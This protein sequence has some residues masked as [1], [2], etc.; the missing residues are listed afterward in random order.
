MT[1]IFL[2]IVNMSISASWIVLAV[3]VLRLLLKKAPKWI[4]VLLWGIVAVRLIC[5]F[6]VE[7]VMSLIPSA[8]TISPE[9]MLDKTPTINSGVAIINNIVNPVIGETFAPDPVAS[10]NPLQILIPVLAIAWIVGIVVMLAYTVISYLRVKRKIGTAVWLRDNI[11]QSENVASPFVLGIIKPAIY[12]PFHMDEQNMELVTAHEQAHIRRRDHWWKPLGFLILTLHWFNP[13]MWL[14]YVLLC[15]DI[16]LAC[17]EKVIKE[18]NCEQKADY[19][20][21]LLTCSVNRRVIAACPVAFGEVGVKRRIQSVMHYKKP[22]FWIVISALA[23]CIVLPLVFLTNPKA[24]GICDIEHHDNILNR[25]TGIRL[26]E[27][28]TEY[29]IQAQ[30]DIDAIVALLKKVEIHQNPNSSDRSDNRDRTNEIVLNRNT[31]LCF[32]ENCEFV[33]IDDGVKPSLSYRVKNPDTVREIFSTY[34]RSYGIT[35]TTISTEC[36]GVVYDFLS[37]TIV[38]DFPHISVRWTNH[39][40][41]VLCY[42]EDFTLYK[43]ETAVEPEDNTGFHALLHTI[44]PGESGEE[45]YT[46]SAYPLESGHYRLEKQF[47]LKSNPGTKYRAFIRFTVNTT[48]AFLGKRYK[49]E[50]IV[51]E[52]GLFSYARSDSE[53][54]QFLI[55]DEDFSLMT[56]DYPQATASSKMYR[57]DGLQKIEL[58]GSNFDDLLEAAVWDDG[59]SAKK[60]R[61]N[62]LHAF[63]SFDLSGRMYYLLEQKN[64]D[65]FIAE[66]RTAQNTFLWIYKMQKASENADDSADNKTDSSSDTTVGYNPY[67]HAV[68]LEVYENSVLVKPFEGSDEGKSA[69]KITV[70]TKVIST[71]PVPELKKGMPIRIVYNGAI[72][73]TYPA[74]IPTVFAIYELKEIDGQLTPVIGTPLKRDG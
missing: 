14:G 12:L 54:P 52:N 73:E 70:S 32:S 48:Y 27:H 17:D 28:G 15:R 11:Y 51:Y 49:G 62:N 37:G 8:E 9:I 33:W 13:L 42:G 64:G 36:D 74:G 3:L 61:Q 2:N 30:S 72:Q 69:D 6:S 53:I 55:S 60:L 7:S 5:P 34:P 58:K 4:T 43:D 23:V 57:I 56:T 10:A 29:E 39:T 25:V 44:R 65:I 68:V 59:Y 38:E 45:L 24:A 50:K 1:D 22:A 47:Y 46:L 19:L 35:C 21:A 41:D 63:S 16:E 40:G 31:V 26:N 67:F 18:L 66:G 71:H 20:Q